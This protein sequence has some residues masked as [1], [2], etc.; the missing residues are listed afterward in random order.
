[1]TGVGICDDLIGEPA[2]MAEARVVYNEAKR[3]G[4]Y[5]DVIHILDDRLT[6]TFRWP[7][8]GMFV[9]RPTAKMATGFA[10]GICVANESAFVG[11][12]GL[13][14]VPVDGSELTWLA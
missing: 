12:N 2:N 6:R 5:Q 10:L 4:K 11:L 1:M 7:E 14:M 9:A 3:R 13:E 8:R